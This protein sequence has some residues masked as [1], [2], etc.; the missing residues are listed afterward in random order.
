MNDKFNTENEDN[1]EKEKKS[2]IKKILVNLTIFILL[3]ILTF[4]LVLKDQDVSQ[5]FSV[6]A[7]VKK[8]YIL[9]AVLAMSIYILGEAVN[10]TRILKELGE[11]SKLI[12][13]I[14]YTLIGFFFSAITPAAS[15]GQPMEIYYMHKDDISVANSTLALLMQLCSLQ[16]VTI[17]VGTISAVIHFEVL[18]SGLIYLLILGIILNSSALMLLIIAIFSKKLSEGLIKIVVKLLKFFRIPNVEKKQE[19]LEKELESYQ[20]SAR[21]IKEHKIK[22]PIVYIMACR[23]GP[24]AA[25]FYKEIH[26]LGGTV[27]LNPD[28]H[29]W[30]RAKWSAPIRKYW[31]ISEQMMVKYCDLAICDSVNIEKYIHECYD[32]K[33]IKGRNPKTTFIAYGADLTLSKLV[34][35]DEKLVSWYKEKGLTKKEYY[36]VVGR[37]VP[38]NSFEVMIREF[39]KSKSKKEFAIITNVNDKFLNE[40][41]EK[42]HFKSD[43]R[44]KFVGTVYDQELL[45]KIRENAYAYFHG[46]TVG[47]TNPSLIEALGST[48]LNLLVDVGFNKEV[49][50]DC[51]LYWS[52]KPGNLAKL[53]DKADQMNAD[54]IAEMGRR[55][56]KRVAEE[57]TWDKICG[58]YEKVFA[59][60]D[61]R[62]K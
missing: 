37:F 18:K 55:A 3:I 48:D 7:K 53:I 58:Q 41:E 60:V 36:L 34:D 61:E 46:H 32:G 57:Y 23:I 29:E 59:T 45:K 39:M 20:T 54:E 19:K 2:K 16:I 42:L 15:G 27:Y 24:F 30:M 49:A 35:D 6:A 51:A 52:R 56:K 14:R 40:L 62:D 21:Y 17:T 31:K 11:K 9:F 33:G 28:G 4:S 8:Q 50:E 22:N 43:K 25:H 1:M 13:N 26:A 12:S 47:G 38:E 44:I 10:I 5:I